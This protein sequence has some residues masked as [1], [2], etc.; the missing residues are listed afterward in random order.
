MDILEAF[1][2]TGGLR[3]AAELAGCDHKNVAHYVGVA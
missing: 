3:A 2:F 1:D